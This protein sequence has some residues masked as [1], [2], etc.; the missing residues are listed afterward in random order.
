M[1][2]TAMS[3]LPKNLGSSHSCHRSVELSSYICVHCHLTYR[4]GCHAICITV[5]VGFLVWVSLSLYSND[6]TAERACLVDRP[7]VGYLGEWVYIQTEHA[8]RVIFYVLMHVNPLFFFID[9]IF[10]LCIFLT[11][12]APLLVF[13]IGEGWATIRLFFEIDGLTWM[14]GWMEKIKSS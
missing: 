12:W 6:S 11:F 4:F 3:I 14:D 5:C 9:I 7:T 13:M 1:F 10:F 2:P 8:I